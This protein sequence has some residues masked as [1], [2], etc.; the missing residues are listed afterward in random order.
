MFANPGILL[1]QGT[2]RSF[3]KIIQ[4]LIRCSIQDEFNFEPTDAAIWSSIRSANI[5]RLTRN[6]L[7]KCLHNVFH[8]GEFW[9]H[10]PNLEFLG[11]CQTCRVPESMEHILLE[12]NARG[13]NQVWHLAEKLWKSRYQNWP[14]LNWGLVLGCGLTRFKSLR[15]MIVPAKNR[16]F[17]IIVSLSSQ[18]IWNLRNEC[19]FETHTEASE[20]EIYNRWLSMVNAAQL[21][22]DTWSGT[23][24][25]EDSLPDDWI[26][27]K[28]V[29]VGIWPINNRFGIG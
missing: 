27:T 9:D 19:V 4:S 6:F 5:H 13:Q 24:A 3:T 20:T 12:C 8:V 18:L 15:G 1:N 22:L 29:L 25:D 17:T 7:W 28:G 2:Q 23:L 14:N 26:N 11:E 10:V 16:F 21:V